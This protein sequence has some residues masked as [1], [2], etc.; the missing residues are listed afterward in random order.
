MEAGAGHVAGTE[1]QANVPFRLISNTLNGLG[2]IAS[3]AFMD[4]E[5]NNNTAKQAVPGLSKETYQLTIYYERSGFEARVAARKRDKYL[6]E[7]Y[8]KSLSL[9]PTTDLGATLVD[10]QIGYNFKDSGISSLDGLTVT[11]QAQNLTDEPTVATETGDSR[12]ILKYQHF[13]TNYLL[14]FSYKF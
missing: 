5:I 14:G 7:T 4:G 11:L 3:A 1:F 10:A 8:G 6:S 2:V 9:V 13:G 12:Q